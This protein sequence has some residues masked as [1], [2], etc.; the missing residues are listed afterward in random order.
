MTTLAFDDQV[1]WL[2]YE[3]LSRL[4]HESAA[5]DRLGDR[6]LGPGVTREDELP[7]LKR[8]VVPRRMSS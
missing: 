1:T 5:E 3:Y 6:F 7:D 4:E 2:P 8:P